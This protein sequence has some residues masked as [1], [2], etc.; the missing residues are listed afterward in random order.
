LE[1]DQKRG[2]IDTNLIARSGSAEK[3]HATFPETKKIAIFRNPADRFYS[4]YMQATRKQNIAY[5]LGDAWN[6][7]RFHDEVYFH[8]L[9][10]PYLALFRKE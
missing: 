2:E 1:E 8:R 6:Q 4:S 9:L 7:S 10:E 3:L 5:P